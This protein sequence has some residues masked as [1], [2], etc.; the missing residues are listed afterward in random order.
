MDKQYK[1]QDKLLDENTL[2]EKANKQT[3][4]Q[5]HKDER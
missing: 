3:N 5:T 4:K 2:M 1:A